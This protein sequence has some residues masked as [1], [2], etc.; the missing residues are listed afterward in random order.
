[1]NKKSFTALG[2][3]AI[4]IIGG[5]VVAS[6]VKSK[7]DKE[8]ALNVAMKA[9][10]AMTMIKGSYSAYDPAKLVNAEKG[11][12]VLNFSASWCPTCVEAN[13]NFRASATPEGLTLLEV[14]YDNS[15]DLKR[16][17]GVTYQH[18]FVQVDKNGNLLKKWS[19]TSTY[20]E[21]LKQTV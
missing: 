19:G 12:V 11:K 18:T 8:V 10:E 2:I 4:V 7:N 15:T 3:A 6:T 16:K 13:K 17:Y 5:G 20:D 9:E 14:D 1:M 21:L